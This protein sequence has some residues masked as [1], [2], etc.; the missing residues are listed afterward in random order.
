[1]NE[2]LIVDGSHV[3]EHRVDGPKKP[4]GTQT[5]HYVVSKKP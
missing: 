4:R 5:N 3:N 2:L 1:M